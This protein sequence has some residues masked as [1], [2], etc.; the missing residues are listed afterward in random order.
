MQTER[1]IAEEVTNALKM[2]Q[3]AIQAH[4]ESVEAY[5][6]I[7]YPFNIKESVAAACREMTEQK[8]AALVRIAGCRDAVTNADTA[9]RCAWELECGTAELVN[10]S[11][12]LLRKDAPLVN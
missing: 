5:I 7:R 8:K 6:A 9:L 4:R 10:R 11:L 1:L 12:E 3:L 2:Y